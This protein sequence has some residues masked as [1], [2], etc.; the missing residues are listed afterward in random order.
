MCI[1]VA[2]HIVEALVILIMFTYF[3]LSQTVTLPVP[4]NRT[5]H[6]CYY[7]LRMA[8]EGK[9]VRLEFE[10]PPGVSCS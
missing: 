9:Q 5:G 6:S 2:L 7:K 3:D 4:F 8:E 10:Q 1:R